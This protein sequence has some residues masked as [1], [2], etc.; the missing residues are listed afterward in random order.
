[1]TR[2][3]SLVIAAGLV[4]VPV[5][6]AL[7]QND[8]D[9]DGRPRPGVALTIYNNDL[10]VVKDTRRLQI[11]DPA[12]TIRF[13]D[14]AKQIDPTTVSFTDLTVPATRIIEQNYE[15]DLVS[16][17]KLL[18]KYIDRRVAVITDDGSRFV[19]TLLSYDNR[20]LIINDGEQL[21]MIQRQ[22]NVQ[23]ISFAELPENL[24]T[25]PTLVWRIATPDPGEHLAR[26]TYQTGGINWKADYV[27][28]IA[29]DDT[30]V[31][32]TGWVTINNQSGARYEDAAI[33]LIAGDVRTVEDQQVPKTAERRRM[34]VEADAAMARQ[35]QEK[36]FFEY[37]MYTLGRRTTVNENQVKQIQLLSAE[38]VPVVKRYVFEPG[39]PHW[40]RRYGDKDEYK[41]NVYIELTNN[42][43]SN[44]GMPLPRG[45]VRV[46][47]ADADE[48]L[49]FVG[50]DRIDHTPKG[51]DV[52][53]YIGDAFDLVGEKKITAQ[54]QGK[55]WRKQTIEIEL[56]NHKDQAATILVRE[57]L[58]HG[59]WKITDASHAFEKDSA[60]VVEFDVEVPAEGRATLKYTVHYSW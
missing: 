14:V 24:L 2:L 29:A 11:P 27:A 32:L 12:S 6:Q 33:K 31:D 17:E 53:L 18:D 13:T 5:A 56:R 47:K 45:I 21:H 42:Q 25:R 55:R 58:G 38:D 54:D 23:S 28:L 41:V 35:F 9:G 20:Q 52:K 48:Q 22:D 30:Q 46:Y 15:Y 50:E 36:G 57:H 1:M 26:V 49:E 40:H 4:A 16:A 43:A 10:G 19:G 7:A 59:N 44:L 8:G 39:G 37:H 3:A 51:E 60:H 34:M